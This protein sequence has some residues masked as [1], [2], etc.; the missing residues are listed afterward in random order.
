MPAHELEP[1][2]RMRIQV[3][4]VVQGVGFRPFVYNLAHE[5]G[6][7]GYGSELVRGSDD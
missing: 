7:T 5:L 6:L 3:R 1:Q 4:G 2:R